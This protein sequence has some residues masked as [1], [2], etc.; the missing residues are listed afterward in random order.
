[1][2]VRAWRPT[3]RRK[4][5]L[6]SVLCIPRPQLVRQKIREVLARVRLAAGNFSDLSL[7]KICSSEID[8]FSLVEFPN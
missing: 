8:R 5:S 6:F 3:D 4:H 7:Q 1:M 2:I